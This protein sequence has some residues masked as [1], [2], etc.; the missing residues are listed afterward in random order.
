MSAGERPPGRLSFPPAFAEKLR[1]ASCDFV[2]TGGGGWIGQAVLEML[3]SALGETF[4]NRVSVF[5]SS[6]RTLQLRSGR[7]IPSRELGYIREIGSR[8]A[9]FVHC[10]FLTKDKL[11]DQS[12]ENFVASNQKISDLMVTA[13]EKSDA[14]GLFTPSSGAVYK[15]GTHSL[16]DDLQKNAYGVMKIADEKRF[17]E[18]AVRK[19]M[20][21]SMPR[22][23]NLSGPFINK[24]ELYALASM[25]AAVLGNKPIAIRAPHKVV[26]SYIHVA[27]LV[28]LAFSMLLD[29]LP[30]DRPVFDTAGGEAVEIG[31]L[32]VSVLKALGRPSRGIERPTLVS[33]SDDIY[34]G[35]GR[36]MLRMM[37]IHGLTLCP[38]EKQIRDTAEYMQELTRA[39]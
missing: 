30:D 28:A 16:D 32:A 25:I 11:S 18:L 37:H 10:A 6:D 38:L 14:K 22:L 24:H 4:P 5:G 33:G 13:I 9:Y 35:D 7:A 27:D 8:P 26:R 2:I 29:P 21:L 17:A 23:F 31:D 34:V 12:V 3:D 15:K 1:R 20:P 19:K 36:E 39:P